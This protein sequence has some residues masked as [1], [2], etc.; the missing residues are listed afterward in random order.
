MFFIL[1]L[2][3]PFEVVC[4]VLP[5]MPSVGVIV[6]HDVVTPAHSFGISDCVA[7]LS[8]LHQGLGFV[9]IVSVTGA[10]GPSHEMTLVATLAG[11]ID[12]PVLAV[13]L[14]AGMAVDVLSLRHVNSCDPVPVLLCVPR[15]RMFVGLGTCLYIEFRA[16]VGTDALRVLTNIKNLI[17]RGGDGLPLDSSVLKL[18]GIRVATGVHCPYIVL[19][20]ALDDGDLLSVCTLAYSTNGLVRHLI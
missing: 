6:V 1:G 5:G 11:E 17:S 7:E 16:L 14:V 19:K 8:E 10:R 18:L 13:S 2:A 4:V 9:D 3:L 12:S 20:F 15:V